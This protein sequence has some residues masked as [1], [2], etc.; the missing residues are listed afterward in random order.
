M[1]CK[2][3]CSF[4]SSHLRS[5]FISAAILE[6]PITMGLLGDFRVLPHKGPQLT[7]A[8]RT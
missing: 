1:G 7:A 2:V 3:H 8:T 5:G 4:S 6:C